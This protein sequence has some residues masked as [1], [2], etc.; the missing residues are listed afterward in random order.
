VKLDLPLTAKA[1]EA[2]RLC[3][4]K[5]RLYRLGGPAGAAARRVDAAR[6]LHA[7]IR[8]SLHQCYR[9]GGPQHVSTEQLVAA[10]MECFDGG[11][12]ADSRE[13]EEYRSTG[14]RLLT[15]YHADHCAD[16][17]A[18]VDVDVHLRAAIGRFCFEARADRREMSERVPPTFV[19]YTPARRPPSEAAL[20]GDLQTAVLQL[21][22]QEAEG[23]SVAVELHALRKRRTLDATK[24]SDVLD[25]LRKRVTALAAAIAE[26]AEY[27]TVRARHC[28]W[29]HARAV[30]PEWGRE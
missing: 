27:P 10:F 15:E 6:A 9:A 25:D 12:S 28:R 20:N 17:P 26:A 21:V 19:V 11:A 2:Y 3:P 7:G 23:R 1:L 4:M 14:L 13:E 30:C 16:P 24:P 29:C 5:Y 18:D 22:A 8:Q